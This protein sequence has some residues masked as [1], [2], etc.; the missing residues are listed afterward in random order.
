MLKP[1][2]VI[3]LRTF[4]KPWLSSTAKITWSEEDRPNRPINKLSQITMEIF[5]CTN[6]V[7][8][9]EANFLLGIIEKLSDDNKVNVNEMIVN[10]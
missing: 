8:I 9:I 2:E 10:N 6:H 1:E 4:V 5:N 3:E 7:M